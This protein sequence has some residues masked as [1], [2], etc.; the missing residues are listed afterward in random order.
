MRNL[1]ATICL[2]IAVLLGSAVHPKVIAQSWLEDKISKSVKPYYERNCDSIV[3]QVRQDSRARLSVNQEGV[4]VEQI[5]D[6]KTL[7]L[8][9]ERAECKGTALL[10]N[11]TRSVIMYGAY[12]DAQND[13]I[14]TYK[15]D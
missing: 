9:E 13:I 12:R 15:T 4:S 3:D 5:Y 14:I 11:N 7:V 8:L 10:S 1:T 6:R 2:T